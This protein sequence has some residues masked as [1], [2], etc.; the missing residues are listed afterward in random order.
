VSATIAVAKEKN[1]N[2]KNCDCALGKSFDS[3]AKPEKTIRQIA[4]ECV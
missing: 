3:P 1:K 2:K 4:F